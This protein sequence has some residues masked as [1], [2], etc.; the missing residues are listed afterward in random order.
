MTINNRRE[1]TSIGQKKTCVARAVC[2]EGSSFFIKVNDVPLHLVQD[3]LLQAKIKEVVALIRPINLDGLEIT[4]SIP[5]GG[6][7]ARVYAAVQ[8][9]AKSVLAYYGK[10]YDE[11]K[12]VEIENRIRAFDRSIIITDSRRREPKKYGGPGARARYQ[13]SYR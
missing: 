3:R 8:A 2:K 1:V 10:Y 5:R 9:F 12:K 7:T 6:P 4:I 13:K 11:W